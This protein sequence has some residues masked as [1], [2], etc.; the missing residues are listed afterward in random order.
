MVCT[1]CLLA[2][3]NHQFI[4]DTAKAM[5]QPTLPELVAFFFLSRGLLSTFHNSPFF[6]LSVEIELPALRG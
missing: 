4:N 6:Y 5:E 1:P 3:G 2:L